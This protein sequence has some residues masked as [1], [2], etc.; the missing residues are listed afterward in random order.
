MFFPNIRTKAKTSALTT[1]IQGCVGCANK[2]NRA[3]KINKRH[4]DW[5]GRSKNVFADIIIVYVENQMKSTKS[6]LEQRVNVV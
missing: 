5:Q 6:L 4:N 2:C 3:R 1:C